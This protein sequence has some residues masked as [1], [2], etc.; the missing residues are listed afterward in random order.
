MTGSSLS[1]GKTERRF[2]VA[3]T[4]IGVLSL[5]WLSAC[6]QGYSPSSQQVAAP[7]QVLVK[8]RTTTNSLSR[9]KSL[10][11]AGLG[12]SSEFAL[13]PGLSVA[14]VGA[15]QTTAQA[16]ASLQSDPNVLYVEP[17]YVVTTNAIPDDTRFAFQY[18]L[19]NTGQTG[20]TPDA[21]I[22]APEAWDIE[23]GKR[24]VIAVIDTGVDYSHEDL[25]GNI[26]V[27][28]GE[29]PGNGID[30]DGNGFVDDVRGWDFRDN[31]NDPMDENDHGTHVAG[32]IAAM[33]N[34]RVGIAG[35]NW[36]AQI[37]PLKFMDAQGRG[38]TSD[39]I[40]ALDYA[41]RMGARVS[42]NSWGGGGFSRALFDAI[43]AVSAS[44]HIFVAAAG[45]DGTNNDVTP[46]YP[47]GFDLNNIVSVAA[48]GENDQLASFSNFGSTSVD[49]GAPGVS[50]L[51]TLPGNRYRNLSGTSM[52]AP[53]V[54]G[55]V[56][57]IL[58]R[59][60]SLAVADVKAAILDNVDA[61]PALQG[62]TTSGGRLNAFKALSSVAASGTGTSPAPA[63][64]TTPAPAPATPPPAPAP[65]TSPITIAPASV[66]V[67]VDATAQLSASG[68]VAPYTWISGD[69]QI[70]AV[71]FSSGI[72]LGLSPG[73]TTVTA[74]DRAGSIADVVVVV[75]QS[76]VANVQ[77]QTPK[78]SITINESIQL[79]VSGGAAPYQWN[80]SNPAVA[81]ID[82]NGLLTGVAAGIV[83]VT[84]T[85]A[86]GISGSVPTIHVVGSSNGTGTGT[87]NGSG[88]GNGAGSG[89]FQVVPN[90]SSVTTFNTIS[91]T[92]SGGTPPY[93]WSLTNGAAGTIFP[94]Q[95]RVGVGW[96]T[97]S[98]A[99]GEST[100][101]VATDANGS[102]GQTAPISILA[103]PTR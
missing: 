39:A 83:T 81:T 27:N 91:I 9:S 86:N 68:G 50:I 36:S 13:V 47:S 61:V 24:V 32:I 20:G 58:A 96:F 38:T 12:R 28:T 95:H 92:A 60:D 37:M 62:I 87:G 93:A 59:N 34:N 85:D 25:S 21:D 26:W 84:A 2:R 76:A 102:Q 80:S 79:T 48:T 89:A 65:V 70:V 41:V 17:D 30:D 31:D 71:S 19:D 6:G 5:L 56:S 98:G 75:S 33:G 18:A 35:V 16:I 72:I 29:V 15:S 69:S 46:H 11:A 45:N 4:L 99:A 66:T 22:D 73:T 57:L 63:P 82:A 94:D 3:I 40:R 8:F 55:V 78:S 90:A 23:T 88:S 100:V 10:R 54:S 51:S 52:A 1:T 49:L 44:R 101:V 53:F 103:L 7:Q 14:T 67:A 43:S 74:T 77:V 64:T 42:S 97:A